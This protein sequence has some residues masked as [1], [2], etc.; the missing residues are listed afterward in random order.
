[1]EHIIRFANIEDKE[2]C[3]TFDHQIDEQLLLSKIQ[4]N[5]IILLEIDRVIRWYI[6]LDIIWSNLPFLSL[7]KVTGE[8]RGNG[9]G[10]ELL[11]FLEKELKDKG[12]SVLLSSSQ[13]NETEPQKW[14][15]KNGFQ[16]CGILTG[17]NGQGIGELFFKKELITKFYR[18]SARPELVL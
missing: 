16:E 6:K 12:Y 2:S 13:V 11:K 9:Y 7:I 1:M 3:L 14:H 17:I 18:A 5:Q 4:L 15:R 8:I 10:Q